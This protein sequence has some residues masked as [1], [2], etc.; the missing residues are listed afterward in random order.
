MAIGQVTTAIKRHPRLHRAAR[1]MRFALGRVVPPRRFDGIPGR[2]HFNDFMF[3]GGSPEEIASYVERG[4]NVLSL[5]EETLAA[6]DLTLLDI[7]RWLD[8]GCGY[9]RV[10]RLLVRRVPGERVFA[11]DV[12]REGTDFCH[13]EFGVTPVY[14]QADLGS[15]RL[16]RFD[17]IYAIS[18]ITHLNGPESIAFLRLLGKSLTEN[19]IA[20]FTTH[21]QWSLEHAGLYGPEYADRRAEIEARIKQEG[22]AYFRYPFE[23]TDYGIS[24]HTKEFIDQTME[25][26]HGGEVAPLLYKPRGLDDHQDVFAFQRLARPA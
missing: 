12:I 5:V 23:P 11:S 22:F 14:S 16:G 20:M 15:V 18:V 17:F 21:G 8:F 4:R 25:R 26:L 7:E 10:I 1:Q 6:A 19:G 9:G 3:G 24:W 2:V 13:S